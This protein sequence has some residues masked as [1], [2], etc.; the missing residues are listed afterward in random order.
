MGPGLGAET[1]SEHLKA[2]QCLW[3]RNQGESS[4]RCLQPRRGTVDVN[5]NG[6]DPKWTYGKIQFKYNEV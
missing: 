5:K 3:G 2:I 6:D 4:Q 1:A